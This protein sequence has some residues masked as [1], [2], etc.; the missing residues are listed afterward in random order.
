MTAAL[1]ACDW[2]STNLRAWT[3]DAEGQEVARRD[4]DLGVNRLSP[5]AAGQ[6]FFDEVRPALGAETLRP[7]SVAVLDLT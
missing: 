7:Y 1:L 3:F 6:K 5:G 4:F 2:G